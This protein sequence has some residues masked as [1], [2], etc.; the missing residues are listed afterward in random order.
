MHHAVT[1]SI[2]KPHKWASSW[3]WVNLRC[4]ESCLHGQLCFSVHLRGCRFGIPSGNITYGATINST[5]FSYP[6]PRQNCFQADFDTD[7]LFLQ[8]DAHPKLL[9]IFQFWLS[10]WVC[11]ST[12]ILHLICPST[13]AIYYFSFIVTLFKRQA[14]QQQPEDTLGCNL[15]PLT[16]E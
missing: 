5:S 16:W 7:N 1:L 6:F 15:Y 10:F 9:V 4:D 8:V 2:L 13:K 14:K 3:G 12:R 11:T